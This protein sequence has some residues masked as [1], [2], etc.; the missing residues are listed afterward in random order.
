MLEDGKVHDPREA[1]GAP[2]A[3]VSPI[4]NGGYYGEKADRHLSC[5]SGPIFKPRDLIVAFS[6]FHLHSQDPEM[7]RP[8]S[9]QQ[10]S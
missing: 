3:S 1:A 7:D 5:V 2:W 6:S 4:R 10:Y 8:T 9:S